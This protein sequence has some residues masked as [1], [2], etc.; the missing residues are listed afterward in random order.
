MLWRIETPYEPQKIIASVTQVWNLNG[1]FQSCRSH[2]FEQLPSNLLF[3]LI[4]I[5][6]SIG[7]TWLILV[8]KCLLSGNRVIF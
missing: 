8:R 2:G 7:S 3:Y 4:L 5:L 6:R 1:E